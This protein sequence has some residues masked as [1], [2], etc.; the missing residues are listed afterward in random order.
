MGLHLIYSRSSRAAKDEIYNSIAEL[1]KNKKKCYL[2]VP[3]SAVLQAEQRFFQTLPASANLYLEILTFRRLPNIIHRKCGKVSGTFIGESGKAVLT[4]LALNDCMPLLKKYSELTESPDF[5]LS[6]SNYITKLKSMELSSDMLLKASDAASLAENEKTAGKLYDIAQIY[7]S[8]EAL[9]K[10]GYDDDGDRMQAAAK[11]LEE[12]DFFGGSTVFADGFSGFTKVEYSILTSIMKQSE[13]TYITLPCREKDGD[14][15]EKPLASAEALKRIAKTDSVMIAPLKELCEETVC[16]DL[17]FLRN[18]LFTASENLEESENVKLYSVYDEAEAAAMLVLK[19]C[20]DGYSMRDIAICAADAES[21]AGTL[22]TVFE[23]HGIPLYMSVKTDFSSLPLYKLIFASFAAVSRGFRREDISAILKSSLSNV[24]DDLAG[25]LDLYAKTWNLSGNIWTSADDFLLNPD[26]FTSRIS[27]RGER[28]LA[29]ASKAK[30]LLMTPLIN[31]KANL[32]LC[33]TAKDFATAL[34]GYLEELSVSTKLEKTADFLSSNGN[35]YLASCHRQLW[36][37]LCDILDSLNLLCGDKE[38]SREKFVSLL[39]LAFR[40][41]KLAAI[42]GYIDEVQLIPV[43]QISGYTPKVLIILGANENVFPKPIATDA[44]FSRTELALFKSYGLDLGVDSDIFELEPLRE[45][46]SAVSL[47]SEKL[48]ILRN[49]KKPAS[50]G[51]SRIASLLS[52]EELSENDI[53]LVGKEAAY[54]YYASNG[55]LELLPEEMRNSIGMPTSNTDCRFSD[56][57]TSEIF[58]KDILMSP[59]VAESF[60]NCRFACWCQRFL[61]LRVESEAKLEPKSIGTYTHSIFEKFILEL[62]EKGVDIATVTDSE[63]PAY[64]KEFVEKYAETELGGLDGKSNRFKYLLGRLEANIEM[65]MRYMIKDFSQSKFRPWKAELSIGDKAKGDDIDGIKIELSGG[66]TLT[67]KG[68]ADRVDIYRSGDKSYIKIADYKTGGKSFSLNKL[69]LGECL[70]L[71]MYLFSVCEN[72]DDDG[73]ELIPAAMFYCSVKKPDIKADSYDS[74]SIS[75]DEAMK[76]YRPSGMVLCDDEVMRALEEKVGTGEFSPAKISN[77]TYGA[78]SEDEFKKVKE[79][80]SSVLK[81]I[82]ELMQ[83]GYAEANGAEKCS[84]S[85]CDNCDFACVCRN[86][87]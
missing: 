58:K 55:M 7:S 27:K 44:F 25:T 74:D 78:Y 4:A 9:L 60:S 11:R 84:K 62:M 67:V 86:E 38:L 42:P 2:I 51:M 85:F 68:K 45:F 81:D 70:Q 14:I 48:F 63:L 33:K 50:I 82:A 83:S 87:K 52:K 43:T 23:K 21:Y 19:L 10:S 79:T 30:K 22:D 69:P 26:G 61:K 16:E 71:P 15:Y 47:P 32:S 18:G 75:P 35:R 40:S 57:V 64:I 41:S 8:Y 54:D 49:S 6:M 1:V 53:M 29:D 80:V 76:Q 3:E 13:N 12:I 72:A 46:Q 28:I 17:A 34:I 5:I 36:K 66:K 39:M 65:F 24:E 31:F 56:E 37:L 77:K 73:K 59:S 20:K